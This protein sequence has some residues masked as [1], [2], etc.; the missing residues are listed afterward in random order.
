MCENLLSP[1][2]MLSVVSVVQD[3]QGAPGVQEPQA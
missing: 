3:F 1:A 2:L